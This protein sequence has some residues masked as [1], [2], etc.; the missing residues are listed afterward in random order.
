[1]SIREMIL[2]AGLLLHVLFCGSVS[3]QTPV[4]RPLVEE[5]TGLWCGW[6]PSGY[7]L[8]ETMKERYPETFV[9]VSYHNNDA[10]ACVTDYPNYPSGFP[11]IFID[12][13]RQVGAAQ[14]YTD[15]EG[16][17]RE[18]VADINVSVEWQDET[19]SVLTATTAV[20]MT[21]DFTDADFRIAYMLTADGLSDPE[22][23]QHNQFS[24]LT[25]EELKDYPEM[26]NSWGE[27]FVNGDEYVSGLVFNDIIIGKTIDKGISKSLP[28]EITAY[29]EMTHVYGFKMSSVRDKE[30]LQ[31][32]ELLRIVAVLMDA[33]TGEVVNCAKSGYSG[34]WGS[35]V[36]TVGEDEKPVSEE[37]YDLSGRRI[38]RPDRALCIKVLTYPSG[39]K[40]YSK[41]TATRH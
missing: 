27:I 7:V 36:S 33:K 10:M 30:L 24:K 16:L 25:G 20:W 19:M 17:S 41:T 23:R 37:W 1:M 3:G 38:N 22:W 5:Y 6:C 39:R 15:W 32:P 26:D 29:E 18:T 4:Y 11:S 12:R 31:H 8:L 34:A 35:S 9:G 13:D 2:M 14:V 28:A 40:S 21:Q